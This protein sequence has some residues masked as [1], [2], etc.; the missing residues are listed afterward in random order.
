VRRFFC[1][2]AA[3]SLGGACP[4]GKPQLLQVVRLELIAKGLAHFRA[5][6]ASG[7]RY[8]GVARSSG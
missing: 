5:R 6:L 3:I 7:Q 1:L 8:P 2:F 4:V